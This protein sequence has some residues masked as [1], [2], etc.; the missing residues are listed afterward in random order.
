MGKHT[1]HSSESHP[2]LRLGL[3]VFF[4]LLAAWMG[5]SFAEM[6]WEDLRDGE[7]ARAI[8]DALVGGLFTFWLVGT[9]ISGRDV[10]DSNRAALCQPVSVWRA[11]GAALLALGSVIGHSYVPQEH[12]GK[13]LLL[14]VATCLLLAGFFQV[15]KGKHA[16]TRADSEP[17]G[18]FDSE[19]AHDADA[20]G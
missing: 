2:P 11:V 7:V 12:R 4:A 5:W 10:L 19:A 18:A 17:A 20:R 1:H 3:R 13:V 14:V 9:A 8:A 15:R 6:V 16:T